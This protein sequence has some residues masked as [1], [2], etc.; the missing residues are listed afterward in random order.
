MGKRKNKFRNPTYSDPELFSQQAT[1][2]KASLQGELEL[3]VEV[4][5]ATVYQLQ[6][7]INS[8][9]DKENK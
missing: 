6:G 4:L 5:E 8:L 7:Q 2:S 3:R 9:L 1:K